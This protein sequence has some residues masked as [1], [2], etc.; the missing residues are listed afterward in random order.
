MLIFLQNLLVKLVSCCLFRFC[1]MTMILDWKNESFWCRMSGDLLCVVRDEQQWLA[2]SWGWNVTLR[3][4]PQSDFDVFW[5][6]CMENSWVRST[7][8]CWVTGT[9]VEKGWRIAECR[10][11]LNQTLICNSS[12]KHYPDLNFCFEF[13]FFFFRVLNV[14]FFYYSSLIFQKSH[15]SAHYFTTYKLQ[16][17]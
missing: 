8:E 4:H 17:Y 12:I 7:L 10:D 5:F 9:K 2:L 14:F 11:T 3:E 15:E 1:G 13:I 16:T 6:T